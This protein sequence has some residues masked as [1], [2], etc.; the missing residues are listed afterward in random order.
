MKE[1]LNK[2]PDVNMQEILEKY[3]PESGVRQL[4]GALGWI[5][6]L[7][8]LSFSLF[9]LYTAIFGVF[10]AQIQRSIHLGFALGLIFILFPAVKSRLK[11]PK[12][13]FQIA[14]YDGLLSI[15]GVAVG[16]YWP[17]MIQD[18]VLR[19]GRLT[20]LDLVVGV[21]AII[22]VLEATRR[23]VGLPITI[24]AIVFLVYAH[25]GPYM[26]GFMAHRGLSIEQIIQSM[27]FYNRRDFR[28]SIRCLCNF[29]LF[30]PIV[31]CLLS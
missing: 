29:Y 27:F 22:L 15:L 30:I 17:L 21:L 26:P 7:G 24:I 13:R 9:Q 14:W 2:N 11:K 12:G 10:T 4:S 28:Y 16:S 19:V 5:V 25:F 1:D 8:L 20:T 31:W 6:F 18:L 3:D 23:A